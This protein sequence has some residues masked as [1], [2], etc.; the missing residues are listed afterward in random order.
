MATISDLISSFNSVDR[1][2]ISSTTTRKIACWVTSMV[3]IFGL[4]GT[5]LPDDDTIGW[6]GIGISEEAKP[7]LIP[8]SKLRDCLRQ[9]ARSPEGV[10]AN[11]AHQLTQSS[12]QLPTSDISNP[13]PYSDVLQRFQSQIAT[14]QPSPSLSSQILHICD[15]IR[16]VD[17]WSLDI[18]LEDREGAQPALIRP[19]TKELRA[20]RHEREE[21]ERQ[22][23]AA[24]LERDIEAGAKADKGRLS[25][26]DMFRTEEYS[27]WDQEG[28][29]LKDKEGVELT[30]S[31][32]K[33]LKKDWE[34]QKKLHE[35]WIERHSGG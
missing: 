21:R 4:N 33:K 17:L 32:T 3:N 13:N 15:Q 16:D 8:L 5:A 31:R 22:K 26:Q 19:V 20:A 28:L 2:V 14:I 27:E 24:K 7:Y 11:Q 10:T 12:I 25:Q 9:K 34:R 18:Y 35:A 1:L 30:K 23:H 6:S 29:P